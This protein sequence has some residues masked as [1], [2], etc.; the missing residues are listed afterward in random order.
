MDFIKEINQ[1][2]PEVDLRGSWIDES[3]SWLTLKSIKLSS[4]GVIKT[5][6]E[7]NFTMN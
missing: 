4:N 7:K 5:Y 3:F 6:F 2:I 1:E